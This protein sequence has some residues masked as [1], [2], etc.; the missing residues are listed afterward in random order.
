MRELTRRSVLRGMGM[1]LAATV[2]PGRFV[3]AADAVSPLMGTLSSYMS[4]ARMRALPANV[5]EAAKDH[6]LDTFAAMLSGSD[7]PPGRA[8]FSFA[9]DFNTDKTATIV[10]SKMTASPPEAALVNGMLA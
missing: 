7:L 4:D 1:G 8:A 6:I 2:L 10:A 9:A 3:F 5:V